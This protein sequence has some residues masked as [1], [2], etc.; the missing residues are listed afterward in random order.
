MRCTFLLFIIGIGNDSILRNLSMNTAANAIYPLTA[1]QGYDTF[2][3]A[4][5]IDDTVSLS[6]SKKGY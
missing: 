4:D 6:V 1:N 2:H 5:L 3:N